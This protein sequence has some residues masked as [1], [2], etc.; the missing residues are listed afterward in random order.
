MLAIFVPVSIVML[1]E[2][3]QVITLMLVLGSLAGVLVAGYLIAE[4]FTDLHGAFGQPLARPML[5]F[6]R[7]L[8]R[9]ADALQQRF[10]PPAKRCFDLAHG[11]LVSRLM[12]AAVQHGIPDAFGQEPRSAAAIAEELK[13]EEA[14][15]R[16]LLRVL[17]A[18]GCFAAVDGTEQMYR[19]NAVSA[20]LRQ[21]IALGQLFTTILKD[22]VHHFLLLQRIVNQRLDLVVD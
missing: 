8:E 22:V 7:G 18:H 10:T 12:Q 14:G 6:A 9:F 4:R 17:V 13:L 16:R 3:W 20:L 11:H 19:H 1:M 5:R 15:V 21:V 2:A